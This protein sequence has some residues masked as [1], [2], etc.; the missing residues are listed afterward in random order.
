MTMMVTEI[1]D[2]LLSA[3]APEE[4]AIKAAQALAS[5][6]NRF[7]KVDS[8]SAKVEADLRLLKWMVGLVVAGVVALIMKAFF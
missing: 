6:D 2:A 4:K 5:Y 3:G 1:Y 8:D 7:N